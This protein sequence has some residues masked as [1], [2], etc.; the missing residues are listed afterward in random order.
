MSI[1]LLWFI[2]MLICF[3]SFLALNS[4]WKWIT[5]DDVEEACDEGYAVIWFIALMIWPLT[6][7]IG[8][9]IAIGWVFYRYC[10]PD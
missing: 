10:I 3:G 7:L 8:L 5:K 9:I 2:G 1:C 6:L 4:K